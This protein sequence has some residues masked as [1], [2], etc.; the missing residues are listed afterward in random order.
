MDRQPRSTDRGFVDAGGAC[1][2]R[3]RQG[4][5]GILLADRGATSPGVFRR[6]AGE[7]KRLR[8]ALLAD[9]LEEGWPSM[10]LVAEMLADRLNREHAATID[11]TLIRPPLPRRLSR[12]SAQRLAFGVDRMAGRLWDYPRFASSLREHFDLFHV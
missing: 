5:L 7:M 10:D 9:Y 6:G 1:R 12:V 8:V 2:P 4:A 11:V 3:P